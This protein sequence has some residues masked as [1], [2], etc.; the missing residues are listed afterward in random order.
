MNQGPKLKVTAT[1]ST[2]LCAREVTFALRRHW[3]ATAT[4][5][6][7]AVGLPLWA[8][9]SRVYRDGNA[10]VEELTG[11]LPAGREVHINTDLGDVRVQGNSTACV[12]TVRKRSYAASQEAARRQFE[13]FRFNA[14]RTGEVDSLE[15]RATTPNMNRFGVEVLVQVPHALDSVKV[16]TGGGALGFQAINGTVIGTTGGGSVRLDNLAGPVKIKSGGGNV[17][18][19]TL[20]A[21]VFLNLGGGVVHLEN[22]SGQSRIKVGGG[23][24]YIGSAHGADIQT[25]GGSIE[26]RK[27]TG[28]LRAVTGG[29]N[30]NLGD[31]SGTVRA[32]SMGGSVH[33][34]SAKGRVEVA[35]GGGSVE[36]YKLVQGA[37]V[38]TG[39]GAIT[40]EFVGSRGSF[41]DS[42]LRT[43]AGDVT[44]FLPSSLPVTVHAS[45]DMISG[46]G[47]HSDFPGLQI[48][49]E[50]GSYGP[51]SMW[52]E[53]QLNGGGALLRVR[54]TI[55]QIDFRRSQ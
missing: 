32:E 1:G 55:G 7:V 11:T 54:T 15:G 26:V 27:C 22:V 30:I 5:A 16:E 46:E 12:Y 25:G 38:E 40:V 42:N 18:G 9:Q 35:T 49:Q 20:G 51:K 14:V 41:S 53:G 13:E 10:W 50:G 23:K 8:Q 21:D 33:V 29:G 24:V 52:A 44:V 39:A 2:G 43:A 6:A 48:H 19:G 4:L 3:K 31:V 45:S 47:I 34:G 28:D 17:D 37:Q 36:A